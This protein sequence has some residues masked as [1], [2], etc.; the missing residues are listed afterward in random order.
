MRGCLTPERQSWPHPSTYWTH[1][2]W[3]TGDSTVVHVSELWFPGCWVLMDPR[4]SH[5]W[6]QLHFKS[7]GT[8]THPG[9][10][11]FWILTLDPWFWIRGTFVCHAPR[12]Q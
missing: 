5:T 9:I 3:P 11:G 2:L 1:D 7:A 4:P 6:P 8:F 12:A 10:L